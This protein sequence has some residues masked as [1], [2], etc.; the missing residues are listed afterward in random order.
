MQPMMA[1]NLAERR[2]QAP[3]FPVPQLHHD[4]ATI[5]SEPNASHVGIPKDGN[6]DEK[7]KY[8]CE[9]LVYP[10]GEIP[11]ILVS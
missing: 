6:A 8:L 7:R 11:V 10:E 2:S 3:A 1:N 4:D 9:T 5:W